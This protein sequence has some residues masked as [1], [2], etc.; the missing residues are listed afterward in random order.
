MITAT[1]VAKEALEVGVW[2]ME[3]TSCMVPGDSSIVYDQFIRICIALEDV[4][5]AVE[6]IKRIGKVF[7][8]LVR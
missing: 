8:R 4:D 2:L 5:R 6:G 7:D 1:E 3:G